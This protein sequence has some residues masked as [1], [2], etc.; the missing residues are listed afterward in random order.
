MKKYIVLSAFAAASALAQARAGLKEP[1]TL[2][3]SGQAPFVLHFPE[4][5]TQ[6][7]AAQ[8][9]RMS[10]VPAAG[11]IAE[12][13]RLSPSGLDLDVNTDNARAIHFYEKQRFSLSGAG[14]NPISGRPVH[15]MSWRP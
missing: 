7:T 14:V 15:R 2:S 12:A 10:N 5:W 8:L 1:G 13:K 9:A 4:G 6:L 3:V 11:L